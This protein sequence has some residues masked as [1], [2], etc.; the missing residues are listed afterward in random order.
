MRKV[1]VAEVVAP[2]QAAP[3][4]T[5][6]AL[7]H[8]AALPQIQGYEILG[9]LGRGG[10]G[11]VYQA[12][13]LALNRVVALKV[14]VLD[15]L[16]EPQQ[17]ERFRIEAEATARL[18]H[19][20]IVQI[21][22]VGEQDGRPYLTL[23]FVDGGSLDKYLDGKPQPPRQ[24]AALL[25]T[26]AR[27]MAYAH[28][29]GIIHRDL[30]PANVLL[31]GLT[32]EAQRHREDRRENES[33][34]VGPPEGPS[35]SDVGSAALSSSSSLCLCASVVNFLP[36]ITDFGLAKQLDSGL[37][38][39]QTGVIIG[40]PSYMAPEQA[41]G[42]VRNIRPHTDVY[43]LGAILYEVLTGR[44]PFLGTS[45]LETLLQVRSQ[46]PVWPGRLQP[47]LPADLQTICLK[48]LE[49]DPARRY[50]TADALADDLQRFLDGQPIR[51]RPVGRWERAWKWARRRP[52]VAALALMSGL[53]LA[54]TI[55]GVLLHNARL[56]DQI[57]KTQAEE[58]RTRQQQARADANYREARATLERMLGRFKDR[59]MAEIPRLR[60]LQHQILE[61]ALAYCQKCFALLDNPDPAMG[62][63]VAGVHQQAGEVEGLLGHRD[64]AVENFRRAIAILESIPDEAIDP[65]ERAALL[66][67]SYHSLGSNLEEFDEA[68]R[69]HRKALA[70]REELLQKQPENT[71][72]LLVVADS[73]HALGV[74]YH[75][76]PA[77][78]RENAAAY[79]Y[80]QSQ[81]VMEKL[82]HRHP[83]VALYQAQ[84]ADTC[85]NLG[86]IYQGLDRI[87]QAE[88]VLQ[89]AQELLETLTAREPS[90]MQYQLS[91]G[92]LY[93]TLGHLPSQGQYRPEAMKRYDRAVDILTALH[94]QEPRLVLVR[95][96]L[97]NAHGAR[98]VL[99]AELKHYKEAVADWERVIELCAEEAKRNTY[100]SLALVARV[101]AGHYQRAVTEAEELAKD[102]QAEPDALYALARAYACCVTAV[103]EDAQQ[104]GSEQARLAREYTARSLEL[105]HRV[106]AT[107]YFTILGHLHH[108][109]TTEELEPVRG[110]LDYQ[111]LFGRMK[112]EG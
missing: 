75:K 24:A 35:P 98:A 15:P 41:A 68:R 17:S 93:V 66:S 18:Q 19:P 2:V 3:R 102:P 74:L 94:R 40:T 79:H 87:P 25:A 90:E 48:C 56:R 101:R 12:R 20:N 100:R 9:E 106:A 89:R 22:E 7:P 71:D 97:L 61:D 46:E 83:S 31:Q 28:Q 45:P 109:K 49:K 13:Q 72:L 32:T 29:R 65:D 33:K 43:A 112:D 53:A 99:H 80:E 38:Q 8:E 58:A 92:C 78:L 54:G 44:P 1:L 47:G 34:A 14:I 91:L 6:P 105:L 42:E 51:A 76:H 59:R 11:I 103:R 73:H 70:L 23:E 108:L 26:L 85:V 107:G 77:L 60:E 50:D 36:K 82:V 86:G 96:N 95:D 63:D 81:E 69:A 10:M 110:Q 111:R 64:R 16:A 55:L 5:T 39:T 57:E 62:K 104:S 88:K 21:Y 52:A 27:A 4:D 67:Y 30:K 37:A 84:L